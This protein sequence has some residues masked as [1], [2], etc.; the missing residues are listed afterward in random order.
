MYL[1]DT[2]PVSHGQPEKPYFGVQFGPDELKDADRIEVW[3]SSF[4]DAGGDFCRYQIMR[5]NE[6]LYQI[7]DSGY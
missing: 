1:V 2:I 7:E 4:E 3:G 6:V 5:E